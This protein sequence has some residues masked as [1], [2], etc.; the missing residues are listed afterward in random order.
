M[1]CITG[2][3]D[4]GKTKVG[5]ITGRSNDGEQGVGVH[6]GHV[7][8]LHDLV[9]VG[10]LND[11]KGIDPEVFMAQLFSQVDGVRDGLRDLSNKRVGPMELVLILHFEDQLLWS[12]TPD[13]TERSKSQDRHVDIVQV[14]L[15][16][17]ALSLDIDE[18]EERNWFAVP[19]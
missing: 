15:G 7:A 19:G 17:D 3:A 11:A 5:V 9:V 4:A 18:A 13:V 8:E 12:D 6:I 2:V 16:N 14:V 10:V 1:D